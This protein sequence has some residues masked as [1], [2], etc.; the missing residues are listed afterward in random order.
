MGYDIYIGNTEMELIDVYDDDEEEY[1]T[2]Y[3]RVIDGKV[4]YY[5]P[6]VRSI[7]QPDA[8]TFPGDGMTSNGNDRHPGYGQW[9]S[10]LAMAGLHSLFF[11]KKHGLMREHPGHAELKSW[12]AEEIARALSSFKERYPHA[13]PHFDDGAMP[14]DAN[15]ARLIWLDWWVKWALEHCEHAGIYNF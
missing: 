10:F 14:E 11:N 1:V 3:S 2:P 15:L 7:R 13:T 9:S 6:V 8:P 4:R 5:K 12:H